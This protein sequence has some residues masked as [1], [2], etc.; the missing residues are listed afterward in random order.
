M[1]SCINLTGPGQKFE[2]TLFLGVSVRGF[3]GATSTGIRRRESSR[4]AN[5]QIWLGKV[6]I[7][8]HTIPPCKCVFVTF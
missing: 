1:I 3:L 7:K 4:E 5:F 8:E 2:Q 6:L